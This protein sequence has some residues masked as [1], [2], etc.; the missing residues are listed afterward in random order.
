MVK[1]TDGFHHV[2]MKVED[3]DK[4]VEFYTTGLGYKKGIAWGD[5]DGRAVMIDVGNE[6]FIEIFAGGKVPD[7]N[8]GAFIH[9]ALKSRNCE[10]DI[11]RAE[12]AGAVI[13]VKVM[14]VDIPSNPVKKVRI[15]FC[16]GLNGEILEFFQEL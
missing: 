14:N 15:A 6:N 1:I 12:K 10:K 5:G 2:A 11:D 3:F 13:T 9:I 16:R 7:E 4:V 8:D